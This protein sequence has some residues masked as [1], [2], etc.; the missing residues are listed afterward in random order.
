MAG[1][2]YLCG[3]IISL[4]AVA[5]ALQA[6]LPQI[7][8][9]FQLIGEPADPGRMPP[10]TPCCWAVILI[11]LT[12]VINSVGVRLMA[13]INNVGVIAELI[14]V[15]VL[16]AV[17]RGEHPPR[18]GRSCSRRKVA[19]MASPGA[20]WGRSWRRRSWLLM[21]CTGSTRP[22]RW[23]KRPTNL[24]A[25][26]PGRS[27]RPCRRGRSG[28]RALDRFSASWRSATRRHA[29]AGPDQRRTAVSGQGCAR[30]QA[31]DVVPAIE[32][33]FRRVCLCPGRARR[34]RSG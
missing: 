18:S 30:A 32:V 4:A 22:A 29:R 6:T 24:A 3:S 23:P 33:D 26:R 1:W 27:C 11:A 5:L 20:I 8:P 9:V 10:R 31:R 21:S 15:T 13:R 14:G 17:A 28:R 16:I 2:V 12:T 34:Q 19:A 25:V 7:A